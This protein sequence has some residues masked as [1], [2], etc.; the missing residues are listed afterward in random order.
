MGELIEVSLQ[1]P[2][3]RLQYVFRY[4]AEGDCLFLSPVFFFAEIYCESLGGQKNDK[5]N[6]EELPFFH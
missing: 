2:V 6:Y 3:I 4:G 5:D 1:W